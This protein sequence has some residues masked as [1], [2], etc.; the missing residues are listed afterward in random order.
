MNS[1]LKFYK[2]IKY[3]EEIEIAYVAYN[4]GIWVKY[5]DIGN[6]FG[7][8][9]TTYSIIWEDIKDEFKEKINVDFTDRYGDVFTCEHDFIHISVILDL[10]RRNDELS[11]NARSM[12][13]DL[14]KNTSLE[15]EVSEAEAVNEFIEV[16]RDPNTT[17]IKII[18]NIIDEKTK[19][20]E[21]R[22]KAYK[23]SGA[24]STCPSWI[25][26]ILK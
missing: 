9:L 18:Y 11:N 13:Y 25:K 7:Y 16:W 20:R 2:L 12:V 1:E 14:E 3:G 19:E 8:Q 10:A 22:Y 6:Y 21:E 24:K 15:G 4:D 23:K 5:R 26:D 17:D